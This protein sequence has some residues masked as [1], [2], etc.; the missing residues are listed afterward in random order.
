MKRAIKTKE[1]MNAYADYKKTKKAD[2][3]IEYRINRMKREGKT[4]KAIMEATNLNDYEVREYLVYA[5]YRTNFTTIPEKLM[6]EIKTAEGR[7]RVR[8]LDAEDICKAIR[9]V[10][11]RLNGITKKAMK[12]IVF[13]YDVNAQTFPNAYKGIPESTLFK[14][15]FD[16]KEW[17]IVDIWRGTCRNKSAHIT[18]TEEAK[19]AILD[20]ISEF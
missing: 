7:A 8:T 17:R 6:A 3:L 5:K 15:E 13:V 2:S 14:A 16:G 10:E 20:K 12:G 19:K 18:L 1:I 11:D 4:D 9:E